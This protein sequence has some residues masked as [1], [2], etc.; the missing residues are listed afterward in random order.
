MK[1]TLVIL[2]ILI[3]I[4]LFAQNTEPTETQ[5]LLKVTVTNYKEAPRQNEP[6]TFESSKTKEQYSGVTNEKGKFSILVPKGDTY[7]IKYSNYKENVEYNKLKIDTTKDIVTIDVKIKIDPPKTFILDN[8]LFDTGKATL[9]PSSYK[10]MNNLVEVMKIKKTMV[11]EIGGH[12]DN[13]GSD[14]VNMQLSRERAMT[15]RS[16]LIRKG[17]SPERVTAKGYGD[18]KP[19]N[20]NDTE[21]GRKQNRRTEVNIIKE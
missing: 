7:I 13:V 16:Y 10:S 14:K 15:V 18:S 11:I 5:A 17:I 2:C 8:V 1:R 12:T 19:I 21:E 4:S 3:S 9:K 6:I 20:S